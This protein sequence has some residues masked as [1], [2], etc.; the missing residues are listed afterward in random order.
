MGDPDR[1]SKNE[2]LNAAQ[3]SSSR[4]VFLRRISLNT[5]YLGPAIRPD[6]RVEARTHMRDS[7]KLLLCG[8]ALQGPCSDF[9]PQYLFAPNSDKLEIR[10]GSIQ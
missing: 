5:I 8:D 10:L 9:F 1:G 7:A 4:A 6:V 3:L 2:S